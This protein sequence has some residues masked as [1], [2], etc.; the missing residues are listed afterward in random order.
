MLFFQFFL[1]FAYLNHAG[2]MNLSRHHSIHSISKPARIVT[3]Q[4]QTSMNVEATFYCNC[5]KCCGQWAQ[6]NLTASGT[7]PI[8]GKTI[9]V[10]PDVIPLGSQILFVEVPSGLEYLQFNPDGSDKVFYAEDTG[11]RDYISGNR[12]DIFLNNHDL[13]LQLGVKQFTIEIIPH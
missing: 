11:N 1:M 3:E 5:E 10:D 13:A 6:Y 9:A 7:T 4:T 12:I 8:E 2:D